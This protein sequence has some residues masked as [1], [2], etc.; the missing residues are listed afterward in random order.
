MLGSTL[1][2][3]VVATCLAS[4]AQ[5]EEPGGYDQTIAAIKQAITTEDYATA[6]S[7]TEILLQ[8]P[9][10]PDDVAV[11]AL[12]QLSTIYAAQGRNEEAIAA[13][14]SA[15]QIAPSDFWLLMR[16]CNLNLD[17]GFLAPA[18]QDCAMA[19]RA[20][21]H[22]R[23]GPMQE[24][25]A[26]YLE[27]TQARLAL[28]LGETGKG[29]H[30]VTLLENRIENDSLAFGTWHVGRLRAEILSRDG[31][32]EAALARLDKAKT[33]LNAALSSPDPQVRSLAQAVSAEERADMS[34]QLG[35]YLERLDRLDAALAQYEDAFAILPPP[36]PG[37]PLPDLTEA[38]A[39]ASCS[40]NLLLRNGEQ[41]VARCGW[42]SAQLPSSINYRDAL[43]LAYE[44]SG[45]PQKALD[46]YNAALAL[47][48]GNQRLQDIRDTIEQKIADDSKAP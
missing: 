42:L 4:L 24:V 16:S 11:S 20:L 29:Q 12:G 21:R 32:T 5:A 27:I 10:L 18:R 1:R 31:D 33:T 14:G 17:H 45:E 13:I 40:M 37:T 25:M 28:Q 43:G 48:P 19:S 39:Y 8:I 22:D 44:V 6:Q 35:L 36:K 2:A 15:L 9:D 46:T 26:Q 38:I 3:V 30:Y 34:F 47:D 7:E 41:A 23:G